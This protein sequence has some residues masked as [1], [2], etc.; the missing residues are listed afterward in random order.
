[1]ECLKRVKFE[2]SKLRG[3]FGKWRLEY[4]QTTQKIGD[5]RD[6]NAPK[7]CRMFK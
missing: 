6:L 1:M 7:V 2:I 5:L 4:P 3:A